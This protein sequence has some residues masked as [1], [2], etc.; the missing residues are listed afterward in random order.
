MM[1]RSKSKLNEMMEQGNFEQAAALMKGYM[2]K[3]EIIDP[4]RDE[5]WGPA[6][7]EIGS[8]ILRHRGAKAFCEY[9]EDM[10]V[11]FEKE[12]EALWG[13]VHKGHIYFRLGFGYF[14]VDRAKAGKYLEMS[15]QEDSLFERN[16]QDSTGIR[17]PFD[18]SLARFPSYVVLVMMELLENGF[19]NS[20][21]E[22]RFYAGMSFL[23]WDIVWGPKEADIDV[24]KKSIGDIV[25]GPEAVRIYKIYGELCAVYAQR[26][27]SA[28]L[29]MICT[30]MESLLRYKLGKK[31]GLDELMNAALAGNVFPNEKIRTL[32]M[33]A[34][35]LNKSIGRYED[36]SIK[37]KLTPRVETA[38]TVGLKILLDK[39]LID[40]AEQS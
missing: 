39:S 36:G 11:F 38:I 8:G 16:Y 40:W 26:L 14:G 23:N 12:L 6:A 32:F 17:I 27:P 18:E 10:L 9:W 30:F 31:S 21:E 29:S 28:T 2:L 19:A 4:L 37:Y 13:H 20:Q 35:L 15:F 3:A 22:Q 1:Q 7:D 34:Y 25:K 33:A 5:S 24:V